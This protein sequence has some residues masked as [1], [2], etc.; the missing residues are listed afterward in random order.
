M[1]EIVVT[2]FLEEAALAPLA[3]DYTV[4]YDKTLHARPEAIAEAAAGARA[5]IVRNQTRVRG[6]LLAACTRLEAVGRLGVGLDNIDLEAC[7]AR[8]IAVLPASGANDVAVAEY[9]IAGLLM[10]LRGAFFASDAVRGGSWPR[11][12]LIGREASGKVLGLVGY[13]GIAREVA[14]RAA[15]LG[16]R[17]RAA[18]PYATVQP[19]AEAA[20]LERLLE[21]ADVLS[22]HVPLT[23]R[24]RG[25]IG[26]A[27]IA[28][29]KPDAILVNTSRG[30]VV[31]EAAIAAAL[32]AGRLGGA[33]LDVFAREPLPAA[34]PFA[35]VPNLV[36]TPHIAGLTV[37]SNARVSTLTVENVR[38]ILEQR[39]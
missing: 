3:A 7:R 15:A 4:L 23:D 18:D 9:V 8:G 36:L 16:M 5:L 20:T 13:G 29:M 2:E 22:L 25:L 19:P 21:E 27:E 28:R 34:N 26:A 24:T 38:R 1:A 32:V 33:V 11:T 35:G 17:I 12:A 10:L 30:E 37:E 39:P 31:D 6:A 14:A